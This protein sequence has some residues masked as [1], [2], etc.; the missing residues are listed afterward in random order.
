LRGKHFPTRRIKEFEV[1]VADQKAFL[2]GFADVLI[3]FEDDGEWFTMLFEL[4]SSFQDYGQVLRQINAYRY[5]LSPKY[6]I[7]E[8]RLIYSDDFEILNNEEVFQY[9]RSQGVIASQVSFL[10]RCNDF[11]RYAAGLGPAPT[12][13]N[14]NEE[15]LLREHPISFRD[16]QYPL[17]RQEK[18][19]E[20]SVEDVKPWEISGGE[21][22]IPF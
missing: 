18:K 10:D 19:C 17:P 11:I 1:V 21:I 13:W 15:R 3:S 22:D 7:I 8:T 14:E 2:I 16:P 12:W 5:Y 4:K 9:F 20:E 6:N